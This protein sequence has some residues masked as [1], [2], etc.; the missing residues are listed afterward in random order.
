MEEWVDFGPDEALECRKAVGDGRCM[1]MRRAAWKG[2]S[3]ETS[4]KLNRLLEICAE[5]KE[6][7]R[8]IVIFSFFRDVITTVRQTLGQCCLEP[9]TGS[10][11]PARRQ[12]IIDEFT[13]APAGTTLISQIQ[14]GGVGLNIQATSIVI[15]C[16]PQIKPA[17]E[18]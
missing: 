14:A 12:Q 16:E 2:G 3:S 11:T 9:I 15:L 18:T 1:D 4:P 6:N 5:A 17:L 13:A 10:V 8:K 7:N